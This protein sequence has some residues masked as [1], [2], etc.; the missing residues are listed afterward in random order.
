MEEALALAP[1]L[2]QLT[3]LEELA[4]GENYF[5]AYAT[6]CSGRQLSA[7]WTALSCRTSLTRL[8]LHWT[9]PSRL[10]VKQLTQVRLQLS[11]SVPVLGRNT[12]GG[13]VGACLACCCPHA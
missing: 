11:A 3:R 6:G 8:D 1:L 5:P 7:L 4:L 13:R 12:C 9:W 2:T 10:A